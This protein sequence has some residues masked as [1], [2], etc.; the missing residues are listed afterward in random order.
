M[1][2]YTKRWRQIQSF[3]H[4]PTIYDGILFFL[5]LVKSDKQCHKLK[6]L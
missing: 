5:H 4:Q 2:K 6:V 1:I 3:Q